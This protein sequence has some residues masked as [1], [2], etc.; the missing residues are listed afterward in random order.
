MLAS[1]DRGHPFQRDGFR[2]GGAPAAIVVELDRDVVVDR[3]G[4]E[5]GTVDGIPVQMVS[6]T[7]HVLELVVDGGTE[8]AVVNVQP[9]IVEVSYLGQRHV[10]TGP[11]RLADHVT[12]GNGTISAPMP[13]TV[14]EVRVTAGDRV[15]EGEVLG[16][17][18]AMKME[19]A[20]KAPF[21]GTVESADAAVGAQV[22]LGSTLFVVSP[23]AEPAP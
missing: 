5:G 19:L 4:S 6:A 2:L 1:T 3:H 14:L 10:L 13:G 11:D 21:A 17:M 7:N 8:R 9:G 15:D 16:M 12:V 23:D 18:E 20:L 22:A